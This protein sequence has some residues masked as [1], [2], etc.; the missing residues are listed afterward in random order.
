MEGAK[1][2]E[3]WTS[4]KAINVFEKKLIL[5]PIHRQRHW[6]LCVVVNPGNVLRGRQCGDNGDGWSGM[7]ACLWLFDS[8]RCHN[9]KNVRKA[10]QGWLNREWQ[11][12]GKEREKEEPFTNETC[13]LLEPS[14]E[15][16]V[17]LLSINGCS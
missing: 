6:S 12:G 14:G 7:E 17:G 2:V 3:R 5:V 9:P 16:F 4:R 11:Q 13:K 1:S 15:W 8:A 10:M